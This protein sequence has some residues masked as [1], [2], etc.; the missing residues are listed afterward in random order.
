MPNKYLKIIHSN[1]FTGNTDNSNKMSHTLFVSPEPPLAKIV[2]LFIRDTNI[3]RAALAFKQSFTQYFLE[4]CGFPVKIGNKQG[5]LYAHN[6][7]LGHKSP[8]GKQRVKH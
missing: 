6:Y 7:V 8:I 5:P 1:I 4:P 3:L 2:W